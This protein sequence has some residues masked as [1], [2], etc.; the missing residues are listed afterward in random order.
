MSS[1]LRNGAGAH[2]I[3]GHPPKVP[4]SRPPLGMNSDPRNGATAHLVSGHPPTV[5]AP[6]APIQ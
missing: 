5:P 2:L 6:L 4:T 1:A 3:S